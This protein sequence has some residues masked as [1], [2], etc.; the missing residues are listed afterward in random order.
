MRFRNA[1]FNQTLTALWPANRRALERRAKT[2]S[3]LAHTVEDPLAKRSLFAIK[4]AALAALFEAAHGSP[5]PPIVGK[6][7]ASVD[8]R[9]LLQGCRVFSIRMR[10]GLSLHLPEVYAS[11]LIV[12]L[13]NRKTINTTQNVE[14]I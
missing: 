4:H 12:N 1:G 7:S 8:R 13:V 2:A 14:A 3:E 11:P 9:L 6:P 10:H 5:D